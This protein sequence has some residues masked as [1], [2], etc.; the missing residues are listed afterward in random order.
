ML[1]RNQGGV[2]TMYK[3]RSKFFQSFGFPHRLKNKKFKFTRPGSTGSCKKKDSWGSGQF[4]GP[5]PEWLNEFYKKLNQYQKLK[6]EWEQRQ[7]T[8][9][10]SQISG[11]SF[12]QNLRE[13]DFKELKQLCNKYLDLVDK[14]VRMAETDRLE[15]KFDKKRKKMKYGLYQI[16]QLMKHIKK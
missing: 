8:K 6:N 5:R 9:N 2:V 13:F 10:Y 14:E 3:T 1:I 12:E 4:K 11:N 16:N 7:K 15:V